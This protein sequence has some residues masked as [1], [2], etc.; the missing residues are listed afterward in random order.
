MLGV[1][2]PRLI[3]YVFTACGHYWSWRALILLT[4]RGPSWSAI[5]KYGRQT[6]S[7]WW[8]NTASM[9]GQHLRCWPSIDASLAQRSVSA[10]E[11]CHQ[12]KAPS[13]KASCRWLSADTMEHLP[14]R[15]QHCLTRMWWATLSHPFY[16]A[17]ECESFLVGSIL[18]MHGWV[19]I[20]CFMIFNYH[21][22]I[23]IDHAT[24][25]Y[26]KITRICLISNRSVT[27]LDV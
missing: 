21:C 11:R 8:A 3:T 15:L 14:W 1:A 24:H 9:L 16:K 7:R 20:T 25:K 22:Q 12:L 10:G 6:D 13:C 4:L 27:N 2:G 23:L 17:S 18:D 26:V 19:W 5:C